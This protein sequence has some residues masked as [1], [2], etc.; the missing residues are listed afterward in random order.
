LEFA[1]LHEDNYDLC[2]GDS[3]RQFRF[4]LLK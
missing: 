2:C 3:L 1:L 4:A